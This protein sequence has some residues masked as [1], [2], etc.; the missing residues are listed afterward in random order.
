MEMITDCEQL[1]TVKLKELLAPIKAK[2]APEENEK[3]AGCNNEKERREYVI[4][5][6]KHYM[7]IILGENGSDDVK[8]LAAAEAK[9]KADSD[10]LA[11][12]EAEEAAA[13]HAEQPPP[14]PPKNNET[15]VEVQ[16]EELPLQ[17]DDFVKC[18]IRDIPG[19]N[20]T[21]VKSVE[22]LLQLILRF[23]NGRITFNKKTRAH[24]F[25]EMIKVVHRVK[26]M[27]IISQIQRDKAIRSIRLTNSVFEETK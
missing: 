3:L 14:P 8:T 9:A 11:A 18:E 23:P 2:L 7:P 12:K 22:Q 13:T 1:Q 27:P 25:I 17:L 26:G 24:S 16:A 21:C 15:K 19:N 4:E 10:A 20:G 5:L 6:Y